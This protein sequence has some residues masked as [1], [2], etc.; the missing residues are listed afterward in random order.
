MTTVLVLW[1]I[2]RPW[3]QF[4]YCGIFVDHDNSSGTVEF[5]DH[6]NSLVLWNIW[7]P[8]Q[9]FWYRGIFV[10]HDNS[11]GTVEF[12]D[13]DNSLVLWNICRP[14]RHFWYCGIFVDLDLHARWS[15]RGWFRSLLWCPSSVECSYFPLF[16]DSTEVLKASFC[17]RLQQFTLRPTCKCVRVFIYWASFEIWGLCPV[18]DACIHLCHQVCLKWRVYM[19]Q[20]GSFFLRMYLWWSLYTLYLLACQVELS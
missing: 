17:F 7:R 3:Q 15:Y 4:W 11:A 18:S 12:V 20:I 9:H 2:C 10:D 14:W 13:H 16:V 19:P 8:W 6:D 5:V 1:N